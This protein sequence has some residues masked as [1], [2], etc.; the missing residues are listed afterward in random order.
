VV[1]PEGGSLNAGSDFNSYSFMMSTL[2]NLSGNFWGDQ[3][4]ISLEQSTPTNFTSGTLTS[5][6]DFYQLNST[7][8]GGAATYLGYFDLAT[9]GVLTFTAGA[10]IVPPTITSI[11][12]AGTTNVITFSTVNGGS[13]SLLATNSAGLATAPRSTWPVVAGPFTG[14][15]S[16]LSI[17][18][19]STDSARFYAISVN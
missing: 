13:Y 3:G 11:V 14:T 2:G 12:N 4:G 7:T 9:N 18:N 17:T 8:N 16:P 19:I 1:E 5:R 6:A 10:V 15:G